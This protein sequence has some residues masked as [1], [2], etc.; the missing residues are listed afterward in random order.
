[1]EQ[2]ERKK[3]VI[4]ELCMLKNVHELPSD[5]FSILTIADYID[6]GHEPRTNNAKWHIS[7]HSDKDKKQIENV[8]QKAGCDNYMLYQ[9]IYDCIKEYKV[10]R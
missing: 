1:M 10:Q 6:G 4:E 3:E 7:Y 2:A 5:C 9:G 8:M